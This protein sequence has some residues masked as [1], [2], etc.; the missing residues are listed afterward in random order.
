WRT[1][2]LPAQRLTPILALALPASVAL[3]L[4]VR[5]GT[6][7]GLLVRAAAS[8]MATLIAVLG[9]HLASGRARTVRG[10]VALALAAWTFGEASR[11]V[12]GAT[13]TSTSFALASVV[14]LGVCAA[15]TYLAIARRRRRMVDETVLYLDVVA[16]FFG[17][18]GA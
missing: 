15:A 1:R 9:W 16:V 17:V 10:W 11:F 8:A 4:L 12:T 2:A 3:A 13:G 7:G 5:G 14:A 18:S 6:A